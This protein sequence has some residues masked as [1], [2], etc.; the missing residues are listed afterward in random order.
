MPLIIPADYRKPLILLSTNG[1]DCSNLSSAAGISKPRQ[2]CT[3][4]AACSPLHRI[5]EMALSKQPQGLASTYRL[6]MRNH[7]EFE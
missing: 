6:N 3:W 1:T 7:G 2:F 5:S 4:H